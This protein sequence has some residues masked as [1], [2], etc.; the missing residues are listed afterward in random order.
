[1][2]SIARKDDSYGVTTGVSLIGRAGVV[3]MDSWCGDGDGSG[4][5][6]EDGAGEDGSTGDDEEGDGGPKE[7]GEKLFSASTTFNSSASQQ[8]LAAMRVHLAGSQA[9]MG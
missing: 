8:L 1:L 5:D 9:V 6:S 7:R 2:Q 3:N 4:F